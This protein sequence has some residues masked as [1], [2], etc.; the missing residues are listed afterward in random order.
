MRHPIVLAA[1]AAVA[2][3]VPACTSQVRPAPGTKVVYQDVVRET[4]RP[5]PGPKPIRPGALPRPL[6]ESPARLID[7]LTAQLAKWAGPGGYGD[8]A[9]AAL[10]RCMKEQ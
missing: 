1:L 4:Q 10:E 7:L 8:Q 3:V 6:P 9:D 5:C 2:L